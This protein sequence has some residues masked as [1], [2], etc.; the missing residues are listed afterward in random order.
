MQHPKSCNMA[1]LKVLSRSG[2]AVKSQHF[3][4]RDNYKYLCSSTTHTLTHITLDE[5]MLQTH[6]H[7]HH[8]IFLLLLH[9]Y[10]LSEYIVVTKNSTNNSLQAMALRGTFWHYTNLKTKSTYSMIVS[11]Y[12]VQS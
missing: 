8:Q 6:N 10:S 11:R 2:I 9:G 5:A 1:G 12:V 4:S 7:P 3:L